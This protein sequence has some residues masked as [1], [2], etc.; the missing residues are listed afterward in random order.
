MTKEEAMATAHGARDVIVEVPPKLS[1]RIEELERKVALLTLDSSNS[2]KPPSSDGPSA[3]P[4]ARAPMKPKKHKPGGQ[5]AQKE[6]NRDLIPA[7]EVNEVIPVL[8]EGCDSCGAALT[9]TGIKA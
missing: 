4:K 5:P 8:P 3:K 1:A 2:T 7:K 9:L 6:V